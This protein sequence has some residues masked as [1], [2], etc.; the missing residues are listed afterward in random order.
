VCILSLSAQRRHWL[1]RS[2]AE[3]S[4]LGLIS[5]LTSTLLS[6]PTR[7]ALITE[8]NHHSV[9]FGVVGDIHDGQNQGEPK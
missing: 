7:A 2:P 3:G 6:S 5:Y 1:G 4:F 8:C 9:G